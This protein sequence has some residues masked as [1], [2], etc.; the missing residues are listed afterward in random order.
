VSSFSLFLFHYI[1]PADA[2]HAFQVDGNL[3]SVRPALGTHAAKLRVNSA[4]QLE[5]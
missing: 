1:L 2:A 4:C 3:S 5:R